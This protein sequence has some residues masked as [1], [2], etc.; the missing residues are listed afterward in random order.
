MVAV[1]TSLPAITQAFPTS[2]A[3]GTCAVAPPGNTVNDWLCI[4]VYSL[5]GATGVCTVLL[6]WMLVSACSKRHLHVH[7]LIHLEV[8]A[9]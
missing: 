2:T 9:H 3:Q 5:A 6:L 8:L 7:L 4:Y 1:H